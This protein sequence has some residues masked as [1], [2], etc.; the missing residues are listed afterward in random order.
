MKI[1]TLFSTL[2]FLAFMMLIGCEKQAHKQKTKIEDFKVLMGKNTALWQHLT[3]DE[4]FRH[5]HL[6]EKIYNKNK[7]LRFGQASHG[8]IPKV[9]HFIWLGPKE[10]PKESIKN[11][12]SWVEKHPGYTFKF[13]TDHYRE[14]PHPKMQ[15]CYFDEYPFSQLKNNFYQSNNYAERSDLLRYEILLNEGGL[16]VDHDVFCYRSFDNLMNNYHFFCGLE[17]PHAPIINSSVSVCNNIIGCVPLHPFLKTTISKVNKRWDRIQRAFPGN[18]KEST[19]YRV[20]Y[21]TFAAFDESVIENITNHAKKS[22][23]FPAGFF[24]DFEMLKGIYAHHFY[25]GTWYKNEDPFEHLVR[26]Q[27]DKMAKKSNKMLFLGGISVLLNLIFAICLI[28]QQRLIKKV[29]KT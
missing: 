10:F 4:D 2:L 6:F 28:L 12:Y 24:N 29:Q 11:I 16:Y 7:D 13:W 20:A 22:I 26:R 9:I 27:L 15:H 25:T 21:R 3:T 5:I 18:D 19:I 23:V 14:A 1:K 17:P 8:N